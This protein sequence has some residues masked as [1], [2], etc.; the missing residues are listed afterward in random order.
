MYKTLGH[1]KITNDKLLTTI[2]SVGALINGVSRI[3]WSTLL[4]YFAFNKVYRT[5]LFI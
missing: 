5:L 1:T 4:D 2:G 3:F